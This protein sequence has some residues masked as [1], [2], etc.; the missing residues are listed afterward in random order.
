M[1]SATPAGR[2]AQPAPLVPLP[3]RGRP[4]E[5][6]LP[7]PLT[8]L[9]GR[10][11]EVGEVCGRL[12]QEEIRLL[13]LT[14]PGGTGKTR[15]ALQAAADVLEDFEDGVFFVALS[16]VNDTALVP[17]T[18]AGALGLGESGDVSL[19]DL[20]KEYLGR[21]ELL[22][23]LDNFEQVLEAAPLVGELLSAAPRLKV[24]AHQPHTLR[25]LR[26]A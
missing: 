9:V 14:G 24:L 16:D 5:A 23:L 6:P 13:T 1:S 7:M 18:I 25:H 17:N 10:E 19:E 21:R 26:R 2:S 12:R 11:R 4:G 20:L 8:P 3:G 22:L 15:L